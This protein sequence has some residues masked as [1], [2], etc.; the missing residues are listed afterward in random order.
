MSSTAP[1]TKPAGQA[2]LAREHVARTG[3]GLLVTGSGGGTGLRALASVSERIA[4]RAR[5][6]VLIVRPRSA[7]H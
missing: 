5:C 4:A 2:A 1:F 7:E 6:S 3:S